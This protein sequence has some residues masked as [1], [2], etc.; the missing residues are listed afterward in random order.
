M[1]SSPAETLFLILIR[2]QAPHLLPEC[3]REFSYYRFRFDFAWPSQKVA[4]E[5]Q[6]KQWHRTYAQLERDRWKLNIAQ[7]NGWIVLQFSPT[8]IRRKPAV[9]VGLLCK[10]L[11]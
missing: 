3:K 9:V 5:I 7:S 6:S 2:R 8:L 11:K 10:V 1:S 4:V